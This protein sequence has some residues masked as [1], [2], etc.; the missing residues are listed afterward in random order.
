LQVSRDSVA[1]FGEDPTYASKLVLWARSETEHYASLVKRHGLSSS[2]AARGLRGA[3]EC[4]QIALGHCS[5]LEDQGLVLSKLVRPSVELGGFTPSY[6]LHTRAFGTY[7]LGG[8]FTLAEKHLRYGIL[9][10]NMFHYFKIPYFTC[11]FFTKFIYNKYIGPSFLL[12]VGSK[13]FASELPEV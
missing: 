1:V 12:H 3:A 10:V 7:L 2:A 5:L 13:I 8:L 11:T 4:V 9:H 6:I